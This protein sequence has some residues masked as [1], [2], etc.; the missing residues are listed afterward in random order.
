MST[1][2][3]A[4]TR[5]KLP[6]KT[7]VAVIALVSVLIAGGVAYA[8]Y[9]ITAQVT[10]TANTLGIGY[11]WIPGTGGGGGTTG[12]TCDIEV[13]GTTSINIGIT[14]YPGDYCVFGADIRTTGSETARVTGTA[15]TGLPSGWS[16]EIVDP[17]CGKEIPAGADGTLVYFVIRIGPTASGSGTIGGGL[18]LSP[19][20]QTGGTT[21][22][23]TCAR[24]TAP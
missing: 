21:S 14:G 3:P 23:V 12:T 22:N 13:P 1:A 6:R 18:T 20:S 8:I 2:T 9:V 11:E 4:R 19:K 17:F 24:Q 5:R 7:L 15:L 10:G 16:A